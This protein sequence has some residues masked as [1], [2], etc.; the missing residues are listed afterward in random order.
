MLNRPSNGLITRV[1][2]LVG[3]LLA[4]SAVLLLSTQ[5]QDVVLAQSNDGRAV[6][7]YQEPTNPALQVD[8]IPAVRDFNSEDPEGAGIYWDVTGLDADHFEISA[9]GVLRF[10]AKPDFENPMNG[11]DANNDG[12]FDDIAVGDELGNNAYREITVRATEMR[13]EGATRRALSTEMDVTVRVTD[14]EERGKVTLQ[15]LEPEVGTPIEAELDDPDAPD[16]IPAGG[17]TFTW[18]VDKVSGLPNPASD[19]HWEQIIPSAFGPVTGTMLPTTMYTPR[20]KRADDVPQGSGPDERPADSDNVAVDE[21][22][23]LRVVAT[24]PGN[25]GLEAYGMSMY[26]IRA[27]RTSG[28]NDSE[29]GSPDFDPERVDQRGF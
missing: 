19:V 18:W 24:Y 26:P 23:Y 5:P 8:D 2:V 20:G 22:K 6:I 15:W 3:A 13:P 1:V 10:K 28:E 7:E 16:G 29:N 17:V 25:G 11:F 9:D 14:A 27:E 4:I 21:G 12:D